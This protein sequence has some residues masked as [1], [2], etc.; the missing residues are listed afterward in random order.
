[1]EGGINFDWMFR[2]GFPEKQNF[3]WDL[4]DEFRIPCLKEKEN[5]QE[6]LKQCSR[7]GVQ[8]IHAWRSENICMAWLGI[9]RPTTCCPSQLND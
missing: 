3:G 8:A 9:G 7:K 5:K 6:S 2:K 4:E 1:M